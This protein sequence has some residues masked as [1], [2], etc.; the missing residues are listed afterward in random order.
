MRTVCRRACVG[1][2]LATSACLLY[3]L[4]SRSPRVGG[5]RTDG[6]PGEDGLP[7]DAQGHRAVPERC[8]PEL[9]AFLAELA[10]GSES[11][12]F[13]S[14]PLKED[15]RSVVV[16]TVV[17]TRPVAKPL[18]VKVTWDDGP[19]VVR[20]LPGLECRRQGDM[21]VV[22]GHLA[23]VDAVPTIE[24]LLRKAS[25]MEAPEIDPTGTLVHPDA[26][27][28]LRLVEA[29][30]LLGQPSSGK[31]VEG[32]LEHR[33]RPIRVSAWLAAQRLHVAHPEYFLRYLE[34][35][36]SVET[37]CRA[38]DAL[39]ST[40]AKSLVMQHV[41]RFVDD[42]APELRSAAIECLAEL[43]V[44]SLRRI[45]LDRLRVEADPN[46]RMMLAF[47]MGK[48][49]VK[50]DVPTLIQMLAETG[51]QGATWTLG[52]QERTYRIRDAAT[53]ALRRIT[54]QPFP[55]NRDLWA[56]WWAAKRNESSQDWATAGVDW[57][58]EHLDSEDIF[59]R[60]DLREYLEK[61]LPGNAPPYNWDAP[62]PQLKDA[63]MALTTWWKSHK[64]SFRLPSA[65]QREGGH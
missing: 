44:S 3:L 8:R 59:L 49:G 65:F 16:C 53:R 2:V 26:Y 9:R 20:A 10:G 27:R 38:I 6:R 46:V 56:S 15:G 33:T 37:K 57:A 31:V 42:P 4:I 25:L 18:T 14:Q 23:F 63:K 43:N 24:E 51:G 7:L 41:P 61:V 22:L 52:Q 5:S 28:I 32:F 58:I 12:Y 34:P 45:V 50:D 36:C 21:A 17:R 62:L 11:G 1:A 55:A 64:S 47:A 29:L 60:R 39:A 54:C 35:V 30:G 19:A 13:S 40:K 48:A